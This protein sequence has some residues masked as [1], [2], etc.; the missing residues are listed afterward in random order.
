MSWPTERA[1]VVRRTVRVVLIDEAERVLLFADSDPG[2][3]ELTW[4]VTPGGGMDP[5][6]TE[7]ETAIREV[8]EETGHALTADQLLGPIA[9]RHV[10]HGY[11]DQIVD[12]VSEVF[13][14]A[15]VPGFEVDTSG[16]TEDEQ[17]TL[18]EHRWWPRADLE[19]TDAWL[20]PDCL[21]GLVSRV[22]SGELALVDLGEMEEST[23]PV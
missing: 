7:S 15:R 11:S 23:R 21:A 2:L 4:W 9:R 16:H 10:R 19:R 5:G 6:E 1:V 13:Y 22:I 17:L 8:A 12:I 14:A 3:P 20:W 18:T